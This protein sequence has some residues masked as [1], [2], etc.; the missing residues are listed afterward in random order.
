MKFLILSLYLFQHV[1]CGIDPSK[2]SDVS[3]WLHATV[4][5]ES[6][7]IYQRFMNNVFHPSFEG[8]PGAVLA[9]T[10]RSDPN[11][12]FHWVRDS[13]IAINTLIDMYVDSN[14]KDFED[15]IFQY[16]HFTKRIQ[17]PHLLSEPKYYLNG[18]VFSRLWCTPQTDGPAHSSISLIKFSYAYLRKGGSMSVVKDI[19]DSM[20]KM[21]LD[22]V[23]ENWTGTRTCD[24]VCF[25]ST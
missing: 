7:T 23:I 4:N 10:S 25:I 9:S 20:I 15:R 16:I 13:S 12:A 19:Y 3:D 2:G 14:G 24:V 1:Y 18:T 8:D 17:P 11:Y 21:Y 22:F 6:G 5:P